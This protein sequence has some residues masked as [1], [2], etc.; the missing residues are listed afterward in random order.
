[1]SRRVAALILAAG[2]SSRLGQPKQ[3]VV[4][5][6]ETLV[7]RAVRVAHEAGASPIFV[8][9]GANFEPILR[10]LEA[11]TREV[12]ILI[13]KGWK[14]GMASSIALGASAAERVDADDLLVMTCDQVHVDADH[15]QQ[16]V[17]SSKRENV[18]ASFYWERRGIPALF[19]RFAFPALQ[20][21]SGD[22]G[23]RELLQKDSVLIVPLPKGEFDLD[24]PEDLLRLREGENATATEPT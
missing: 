8:V 2:A 12:R 11:N 18:V 14:R 20:E 22:T 15:L 4:Y 17:R 21:L 13:N 9:L 7:E 23:A 19:P 6:G 1:M 10:V 5:R 3:L 24:T 16:L